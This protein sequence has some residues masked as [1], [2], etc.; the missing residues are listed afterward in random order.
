[1]RCAAIFATGTTA[2]ARTRSKGASPPTRMPR[3]PASRRGRTDRADVTA[4]E[5]VRELWRHRETGERWIVE[6]EF[7]RVIA[8]H[9]PLA[10]DDRDADALAMKTAAHGR[11]PAFTEE[12][13]RLEER[14]DEFERL[15]RPGGGGRDS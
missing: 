14:R 4:D 1:M 13:A 2:T 15:A 7:G 10:D 6:L 8:A 5:R 12:A 3:R 11:S 9:G